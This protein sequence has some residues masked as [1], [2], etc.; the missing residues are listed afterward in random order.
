[1]IPFFDY[2]PEYVQLRADLDAAWTRVMSSGHLILGPEVEAF[3]REAADAVGARGA[4]GVASGTDALI[5]ALRALSIGPGDEVLTVANAGV[6]TIAAIRAA[7]AMPRFVDV[8]PGTL[9]MDPARL[10]AA[11]TPRTRGVLPVH[12]YGQPVPLGPVLAF[13]ARHGL[14]VVEDCAQAFGA[15]WRD[16]PV[17]SVGAVG[18]FSFYPTKTLGAFGDGGLVVTSDRDVEQRL[19]MLRMYG[20]REDRHAHLEGGN[21][22][23]DELQAA[24]LRVK[25]RHFPRALAER[26]KIAQ[27]YQDALQGRCRLVERSEGTTHAW[28]LFVILTSERAWLIEALTASGVGYGIHYPE[29]V[30]LMEAYRFLGHG[31]GDL[32]VSEEACGQVLSLPIFPGLAEAAVEEVIETIRGAVG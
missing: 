16:R 8:E 24:I 23:L 27:C 18:C 30:H 14:H 32:P 2:R 22:R 12:L 19:R 29:P 17:G 11:L 28:H 10:E 21:S 13:A 3:E 1:M 20:F 4:V 26:R 9:L 7:G 31:R 6:P 5:L 25:L 15:T